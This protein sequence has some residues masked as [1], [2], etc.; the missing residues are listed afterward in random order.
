[1]RVRRGSEGYQ[2]VFVASTSSIIFVFFFIIIIGVCISLKTNRSRSWQVRV[3]YNLKNI[4]KNIFLDWYLIHDLP[5]V[6]SSLDLS[7]LGQYFVK[8]SHFRTLCVCDLMTKLSY[9]EVTNMNDVYLGDMTILFI[10]GHIIIISPH[11]HEVSNKKWV[12]TFRNNNTT[13]C[14]YYLGT[15]LLLILWYKYYYNVPTTY[16]L[17]IFI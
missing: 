6:F 3:T 7:F 5:K 10:W 12:G 17:T 11:M 9:L 8:I 4:Y 16:L 15:Y 1:M 2:I 13:I 14:K